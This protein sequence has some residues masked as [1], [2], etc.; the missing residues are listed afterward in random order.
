MLHIIIMLISIVIFSCSNSPIN[1]ETTNN[2]HKLWQPYGEWEIIDGDITF[3]N[4]KIFLYDDGC[5]KSNDIDFLMNFNSTLT[6]NNDSSVKFERSYYH[7][8]ADITFFDSI[9]NTVTLKF[10][11]GDGHFFDN[12]IITLQKIS[13]DLPN[14]N[15]FLIDGFYVTGSYVENFIIPHDISTH[16]TENGIRLLFSGD[17]I[18]KENPDFIYLISSYGDTCCNIKKT[19]M[20]DETSIPSYTALAYKIKN[21]NIYLLT[22]TNFSNNL[23]HL[24]K[25]VAT[26]DFQQYI[27]SEYKIKVP[28]S[29]NTDS[30]IDCFPIEC[31]DG[32]RS[33][34]LTC[35]EKEPCKDLYS[36]GLYIEFYIQ[37]IVTLKEY[38]LSTSYTPQ[39]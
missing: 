38:V 1:N 30:I 39:H 3:I 28:Y 7:A 12:K 20:I 14:K 27:A 23:N 31:G 8:Y 18:T 10:A 2:T 4:K 21:V 32:K 24:F 35:A 9:T 15:H 5:I 16:Y 37:D 29:S 17:T 19:I 25:L 13:Q 11:K 34:L 22:D 36:S 33:L 26:E 6:I